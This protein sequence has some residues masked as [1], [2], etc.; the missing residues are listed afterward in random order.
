MYKRQVIN[1]AGFGISGAV[2]FTS[3]EQAKAQFDLKFFGTVTVNKA[4]LP[5][6]RHQEMCIRDRANGVVQ[7]QRL[8]ASGT[9]S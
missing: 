5:F 9:V 7:I 6:L 3:M 4:V 1:C 2:E 8:I